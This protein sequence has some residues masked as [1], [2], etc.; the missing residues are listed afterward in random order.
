MI[1]PFHCLK[2]LQLLF[3]RESKL[4]CIYYM[5]GLYCRLCGEYSEE[6]VKTCPLRVWGGKHKSTGSIN[7]KCSE[8]SPG[9]EERWCDLSTGDSVRLAGVKHISAHGD[10]HVLRLSATDLCQADSART[11]GM[12]PTTGLCPRMTQATSAT[13]EVEQKFLSLP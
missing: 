6:K 13:Q 12:E 5:T 2:A 3:P 11:W 10:L 8:T 4:N 1:P 7:S 9:E